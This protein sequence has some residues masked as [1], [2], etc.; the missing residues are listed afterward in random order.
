MTDLE[1]QTL[2]KV[3]L[4]C[5]SEMIV[6]KPFRLLGKEVLTQNVPCGRWYISSNP[7]RNFGCLNN[8]LYSTQSSG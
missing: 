4:F 1:W 6:P 2:D 8:V 5:L 7:L 3:I